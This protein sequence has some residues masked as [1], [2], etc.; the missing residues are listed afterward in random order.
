[1]LM[2]KTAQDKRHGHPRFYELLEE[3]AETHSRKN[4]DYADESNPFSNFQEVAE[5]TGLTISQ[6][7][8]VF[9][10]TKV[11]RIK[12]LTTKV[13]FVIGEGI[14]DSLM[15]LAVYSLIWIIHLEEKNKLKN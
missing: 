1:M 13:N 15:D 8:H 7:L 4:H 10:R 12:Q 14:R 2:S 11:A 3:M 9:I 5:G 6:V